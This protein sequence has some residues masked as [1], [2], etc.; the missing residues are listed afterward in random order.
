MGVR[1]AGAEGSC[2]TMAARATTVGHA[3]GA[4]A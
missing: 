1:G 4:A 3:A 2:V